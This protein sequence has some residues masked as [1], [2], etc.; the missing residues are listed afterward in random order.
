MKELDSVRRLAVNSNEGFEPGPVVVQ[1]ASGSGR[2][3]VLILSELML[4]CLE[5]N[6]VSDAFIKQFYVL[7]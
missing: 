6:Q 3:G 5:R 1:C 4:Q 2:T 7:S